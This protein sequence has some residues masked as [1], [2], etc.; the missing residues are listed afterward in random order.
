MQG[1]RGFCLGSPSLHRGL[2]IPLQQDAGAVLELTLFVSHLSE[3]TVLHCLMFGVL[4]NTASYIYLFF[5]CFKWEG[6]F[7]LPFWKWNSQSCNFDS[8]PI[9]I[10][11][12]WG[13][14]LERKPSWLFNSQ[15]SQRLRLTSPSKFSCEQLFLIL[16]AATRSCKNLWILWVSPILRSHCFLPCRSWY[17]KV[18]RPIDGLS[19]SIYVGI[20]GDTLSPSFVVNVAREVW[21][22]QFSCSACFYMGIWKDSKITLLLLFSQN[23]AEIT[24]EI[25]VLI[26]SYNFWDYHF[27]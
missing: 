27:H 7:T 25:Y 21:V 16:Y 8:I 19:P 20:Y 18:L 3:I 4:K 10:F 22:L 9:S 24:W 17:Y 1:I 12:V 14:V 26:T 15:S 23:P 11:S 6:S 5:V 13:S 2:E